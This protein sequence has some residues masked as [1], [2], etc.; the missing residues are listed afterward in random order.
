MVSHEVGRYYSA[1]LRSFTCSY[2]SRRN[3]AT[4]ADVPV[5]FKITHVDPIFTTILIIKSEDKKVFMRRAKKKGCKFATFLRMK[6]IE[7][8]AMEVSIEAMENRHG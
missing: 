1:V 5:R 8:S 6:L 2:A 3:Y 7:A 4:W